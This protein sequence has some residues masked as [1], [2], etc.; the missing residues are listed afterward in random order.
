MV[1]KGLAELLD[2][3]NKEHE[4]ERLQADLTMLLFESEKTLHDKEQECLRLKAELTAEIT[5]IKTKAEQKLHD[6]EQECKRLQADL[7]AQIS[8]RTKADTALLEVLK[9]PPVVTDKIV[10]IGPG[11]HDDVKVLKAITDIKKKMEGD[12]TFEI[13]RNSYDKIVEIKARRQQ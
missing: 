13:H 4:W 3:Y 5:A 11:K 6:K 1:T 12:I 2:L 9:R 8:A 7:T 10:Q